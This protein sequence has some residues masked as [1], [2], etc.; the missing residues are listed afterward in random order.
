MS[1]KAQFAGLFAIVATGSVLFASAETSSALAQPGESL[2]IS[3][4]PLT[5]ETVPVFM[6]QEVVQPL[7][8][9]QVEVAAEADD[10][11][12]AS[13]LKELVADV[14]APETLSPEME[15]LAGAIYFESRGEPIDGQLAVAQV[16]MNRA[17]SGLFPSTYCGVVYQRAQFS[18][19]KGGSMPTI[20]RS[21]SAWH[22]AKKLARI[23][24]EGLWDS[25]AGDALYFH[26]RYVRPAWSR[27]KLA[28]A[29]INSHIFYR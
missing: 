7:P 11:P 15:C 28:R 23:A 27:Q 24:H 29:T 1:R 21:S 26:A 19:V 10:S 22:R 20:K 13:S 16:V 25:E 18:F 8:D 14:S 3:H 17:D 6:S 12:Q 2:E 9:E 5:D 4:T